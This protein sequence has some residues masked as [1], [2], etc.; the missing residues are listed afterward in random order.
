MKPSHRSPLHRLALTLIIAKTNASDTL[1]KGTI[2]TSVHNNINAHRPY[3][4]EK[5][6]KMEEQVRSVEMLIDQAILQTRNPNKKG[7]QYTERMEMLSHPRYRWIKQD[8]GNHWSKI[9]HPKLRRRTCIARSTG[10]TV[11]TLK[12]TAARVVCSAENQLHSSTVQV[13]SYSMAS[14]L[15][16]PFPVVLP[17]G[18]FQRCLPGIPAPW[19]KRNRKPAQ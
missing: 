6:S 19:N 7:P 11:S 8:N 16:L 9:D 3:Y 10:P 12:A 17:M 4:K 15:S 1:S 13:F 5:K 18:H 14:A 2:R